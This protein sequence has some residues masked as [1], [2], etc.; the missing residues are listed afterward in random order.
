MHPVSQ[1]EMEP[2]YILGRS[3]E[4]PFSFE[5]EGG[6]TSGYW[7]QG[8]RRSAISREPSP[9]ASPSRGYSASPGATA[10]GSLRLSNRVQHMLA[11]AAGLAPKTRAT[12]TRD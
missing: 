5:I 4:R 7:A 3:E 6:R 12:I 1:G 8:G 2:P 11:T 9:P 10:E